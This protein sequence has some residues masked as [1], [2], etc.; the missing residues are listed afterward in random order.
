MNEA[1]NIQLSLDDKKEYLEKA[2]QLWDSLSERQKG[3]LEGK[4]EAIEQFA[5]EERRTA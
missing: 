3:R 2:S 5:V 1:N 4:L